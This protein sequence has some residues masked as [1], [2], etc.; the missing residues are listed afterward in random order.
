MSKIEPGIRAGKP[1]KRGD[2]IGYSGNTGLSEAPHLHYEVRDLEDNHLNPLHFLA[3]SM[4][5][6]EYERLLR[7]AEQTTLI[8][9]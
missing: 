3:P 9:D 6:A 1:I 8:F 5:P 4:T 7:E 2:V